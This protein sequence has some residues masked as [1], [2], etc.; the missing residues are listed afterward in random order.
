MFNLARIINAFSLLKSEPH[1]IA[2]MLIVAGLWVVT[3]AVLAGGVLE[4]RVFGTI[5]L[6]MV[7]VM[8]LAVLGVIAF[9]YI[10]FKPATGKRRTDRRMEEVAA[11]YS[12]G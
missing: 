10:S 5:F 4:P 7:M 6:V 11:R 8:I 9:G 2:L 1:L 12:A 3:L